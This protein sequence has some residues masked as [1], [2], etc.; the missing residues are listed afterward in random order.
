MNRQSH[1]FALMFVAFA[2]LVVNAEVKEALT[3]SLPIPGPADDRDSAGGILVADVNGDGRPDFLVTCKDHL[4]VYDNTGEKLWVFQGEIGVGGQ[5]E[6]QG[7]PGHHGP[8]VA[9]GDVDED[10]KCEVVY[11]TKDGTVHFV[12]G[13]TGKSKAT[14]APASPDRAKRWELAMVADFRGRDKDTDILLQTTNA[15][16]YR[17]GRHLA[18][19]AYGDL[20]AGKKPLWTTDG[21]VSCAHNGA[22]LVDLD[23]DG[24]DEILGV[25][26]YSPDGKL[27]TRAA[28]FKGHMDSVFTADVR[29]DLP[30]LEVV[31]LE[32]GSNYVQLLGMGGPIWRNHFRHQEPQNAAL[33]RFQDG[34][35]EVF[36]WCRSRYPEHQKPFVFD[37]HGKKVFDYAMDDVAPKGWTDSGVE[38]IHTI[39]WTGARTQLACAKERHTSGDVCL[40][41]PLTGRFVERIKQ[42]ASRLY[43]ADVRGDW[44][45]EVLV[46]AGSKLTV[47][48]NS[49]T[50]PRPDRPRL[51]NDRNYRRRKQCHNYYSP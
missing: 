21:F 5:S 41:E 22:R 14:A 46:L 34:S 24:R 7:L 17:T 19:Y 9:A 33:G 35:G 48:E 16:G 49:A 31:L 12:D 40:F 36:I 6:S 29:P 13:A 30:G 2:A 1:T 42:K 38:V 45:E 44:R 25:T 27:V 10:G 18:A 43:V 39:D 50:N 26:I 23:G 51:W 20:V 11:L 15:G 32:E 8:G 47:Y 37:S 3:I 4:A 28:D